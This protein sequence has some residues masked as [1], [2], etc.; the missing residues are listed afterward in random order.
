MKPELINLLH[1]LQS[2]PGVE[3]FQNLIVYPN[4]SASAV[5][6]HGAMRFGSLDE[7]EAFA[8]HQEENKPAEA[9]S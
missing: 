1:R 4:G 7:L 8:Y 6:R 2:H 5:F 3:H 9:K